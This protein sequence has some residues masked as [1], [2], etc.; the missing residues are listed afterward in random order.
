MVVGMPWADKQKYASNATL[1]LRRVPHDMNNIAK[2]NEHFTRFGTLVNLQV[3]HLVHTWSCITCTP[4]N[5]F[6]I[7]GAHASWKA[8]DFFKFQDL[9]SPG[10]S[11]WSSKVLEK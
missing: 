5:S 8:L 9:D 3:C 2:I 7:Q 6:E 11:L 1:E 4:A 10:K